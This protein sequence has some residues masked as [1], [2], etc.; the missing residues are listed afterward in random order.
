MKKKRIT[1]PADETQFVDVEKIKKAGDR[2]GEGPRKYQKATYSFT[3]KSASPVAQGSDRRCGSTTSSE[4]SM[5]AGAAR[6]R[7]GQSLGCRQR[8]VTTT[9]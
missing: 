7:A 1:N 9:P 3:N 5:S 4:S 8:P 6:S 2:Q